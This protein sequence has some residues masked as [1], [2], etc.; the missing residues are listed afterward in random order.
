M[1]RFQ[2]VLAV[3]CSVLVAGLAHGGEAAAPATTNLEPM[4]VVAHDLAPA[5]AYGQV[6]TLGRALAALPQVLVN[7]QGGYG[8]Q[9]DLSIRGSSFSGA[10]LSLGGLSLRNPQT[11]HFNAELP[12]PA[13][14]LT[15]PRVVTGLDQARQTD[16]HLVGSVSMDF[17]PVRATRRLSGGV[18]E[19]DRQWESAFVQQP[20]AAD[21]AGGTWGASAFGAHEGAKGVDYPDNDLDLW[22]AGGHLQYLAPDAQVDLAAGTLHKQFGARGY[23]GVSDTL[24]AQEETEDSLVFLSGRQGDLD[25]EFTRLS[26]QW[27]E[28]DDTY[29]ILPTIFHNHTESRVLAGAADGRAALPADLALN[30]RAGVEDENMDGLTLGDHNRQRG[31]LQALPAWTLGPL[32]LTAGARGEVFSDDKPAWLPQAGAEVQVNDDNALYA[33]YTETV[34]QPSYTE[35]NYE[36]P[37]SLGNAGLERQEARTAEGGLK[38]RFGERMNGH[39]AVFQ[40][41]S[42]ESVDWV[43]RTPESTR[44]EAVNLQDV[45]TLGVEAGLRGDVTKRLGLD[46]QYTWLDKHDDADV[47]ASRYVLD[48]AEHLLHLSAVW[49]ATETIQ[50]TG[51]QVLRWQVAN[52]LRESD[53]FGTTGAVAAHLA[54]PTCRHAVLTLAADNVWNNS[55]QP[56]AGQEVAGR[57]YSA[58]LTLAW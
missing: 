12:L 18:G 23:Y 19:T 6:D 28:L 46:G 38:H 36:S 15:A 11:E 47:Y 52:A 10:G 29:D 56:F 22:N 20:V 16:G 30:W 44:F 53:D 42:E 32:E 45:D 34:R 35:L 14:L 1:Q 48:Y 58:G 21:K 4:T 25:G 2:Q 13:A 17:A 41:W 26:A 27:R 9:N 24:P 40:Q 49:R 51:T 57:R 50:L 55:F 31:I 54:L 3:V 5:R 33:S 8:V 43:R 37:G 39:A 7:S